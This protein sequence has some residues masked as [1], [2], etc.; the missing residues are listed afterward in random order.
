MRF[1]RAMATQYVYMDRFKFNI[2]GCINQYQDFQGAVKWLKKGKEE[3]SGENFDNLIRD[4]FSHFLQRHQFTNAEKFLSVDLIPTVLHR[5]LQE[6]YRTTLFEHKKRIAENELKLL[7]DCGKF[8]EARTFF[9]NNSDSISIEAYQRL[10]GAYKMRWEQEVRSKLKCLLEK[11]Q[12]EEADLFYQTVAESFSRNAY[13]SLVARYEVEHQENQKLEVALLL[14]EVGEFKK[15]DEALVQCSQTESVT[16]YEEMKA[17]RL[18]RFFSDNFTKVKSL[19]DEQHLALADTSKNLLLRARAGSGKTTTLSSKIAYLVRGEKIHPNQIVALCFNRAATDNII[20]KLAADFDIKYREKENIATFHSLAGQISP[21]EPGVE[22][23]YDDR[24]PLAKQKYTDYVEGIL[25]EKWDDP[26]TDLKNEDLSRNSESIFRFFRNI[27]ATFRYARYKDVIY[28]IAREDKRFD[29]DEE[30]SDLENEGIIYGSKE[31]YLYRRNLTYITLDGK[32]VKSFGEKCIADYLFEHGINYRYEPNYLMGKHPYYPDFELYDHKLIIEHWGI[33]EN[34]RQKKVPKTWLKTWDDY[35]NEMT[36][37]RS[38]WK[39]FSKNGF[40]EPLL[41]TNITHLKGGR[42]SFEKIISEMLSSRGIHN[43][44]L[45]IDEIMNKLSHSLR[46]EFSKKIVS[47]I[48]KAKQN[49]LSPEEMKQKIDAIGGPKY[50][51]VNVFL[52]LANIIYKQYEVKKVKDRK[53]DFYD[54]LINAE[55]RIDEKHG[56]CLLRSGA[57]LKELEWLLIDEFQDFSPLF[58]TMIKVIQ[59]YNPRM[60]LFC[61]GDD[62]Q[63]INAF[64]G[65]DVELFKQ[66][67]SEFPVDSAIKDLTTNWR[68]TPGIVHFG[69][70]IMSGHGVVSTA[71]PYN[72]EISIIQHMNINGTWLDIREA[73]T[74]FG[75]ETDVDVVLLRYID[76]A[77]K[78]IDGYLP[79][80]IAD[81]KYKLLIL[82]RKLKIKQYS[83]DVLTRKIEAFFVKKYPESKNKIKTIFNEQVDEKGDTYRQIETKTAHQSKGLESNVVIVLEATNRCFPLVHP[84]S[85][86]FEIFGDKLDKVVDEERRLFYVACTRAK[87]DLYLLYEEDFHKT[88]TITEFYPTDYLT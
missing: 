76:Q 27:A 56:D 44:M 55:K 21:Q 31:H 62:W 51:K 45:P 8:A 40:S 58:M 69:N 10:G 71:S 82:S 7:L 38:F 77:V 60:K 65:S 4:I 53:V 35:K 6:T 46:S 86:L 72:S 39:A 70:K 3:A 48:Q 34:D 20:K 47:Y 29:A 61:V 16:K 66:F 85:L 2:I 73:R 41:E 84:D 23:L 26:F 63:A 43:E 49:K 83:L 30:A 12:F 80:L 11:F 36:E 25:K 13:Q 64:A 52:N 37:K 14:L 42:E 50:S 78:I 54:F 75:I 24:D 67:K 68:S 28:A 87:S 32:H 57:N 74:E 19:S 1:R 17:L 81:N 15:A 59:K 33:D 88:R 18:A 79:R 5:E 9:T 22:T